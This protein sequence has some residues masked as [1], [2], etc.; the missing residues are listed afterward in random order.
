MFSQLITNIKVNLIFYKRNRLL[1]VASIFII[2][3]VAL[4]SI[5]AM[6]F[7]TKSKHV[8]IIKMV[9]SEL[10]GFVFVVAA[11]L[12]LLFVSHH[13]RNRSTKMIFTKPCTPEIWLLSG[14]LSGT[15]IC[16][17][18][19]AGVFLISTLLFIIW[20]V[21]FQWGILYMTANEFLQSLIILSY[22]IFLSVILHP[23]IAVFFVIIFQESMLYYMKLF[24]QSGMKAYNEG[25]F[26]SFLT[27]LKAVVDTLYLV[28]PTFKPFS[29]DMTQ[30]YSSLRL[31]DTK[32][33]YL[34][35]TMAYT[36][37]VSTLFYLLS[38]YFLKKKRLI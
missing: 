6:F 37:I 10:S 19:Y 12:G 21:P 36:I 2:L 7:M 17:L 22:M 11:G 38:D 15:I 26:S 28:F 23:V 34:F 24:L 14:F 8:D 18:L 31:S 13:I 5:P 20:D 16:F 25:A 32:W 27:V 35:L 1:L 4:S 9:F 29:E 33:E 3:M 30:V